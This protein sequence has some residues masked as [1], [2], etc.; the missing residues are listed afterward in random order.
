MTYRMS[1]YVA[2][3]EI[4]KRELRVMAVMVGEML[5]VLGE[6]RCIQRNPKKGIES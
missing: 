5:D 2:F 6:E 3:K 4:P 1:T